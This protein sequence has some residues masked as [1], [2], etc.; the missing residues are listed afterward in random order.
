MLIYEEN[1]K[2][3][4][5]FKSFFNCIGSEVVLVLPYSQ[6][7]TGFGTLCLIAVWLYYTGIASGNVLS[8]LFELVW[9]PIVFQIVPKSKILVFCLHFFS[10]S[11]ESK[12]V[13][14]SAF[15]LNHYFSSEPE[16]CTYL[17]CFLTEN[18]NYIGKWHLLVENMYVHYLENKHLSLTI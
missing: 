12:K 5:N 14:W 2:M 6:L 18:L 11:I 7:W 1:A 15:Y 8:T 13:L 16:C 17:I 9:F 10:F 3:H 4:L